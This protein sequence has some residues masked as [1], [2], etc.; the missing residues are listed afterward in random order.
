M[1]RQEGIIR[2]QEEP[3]GQSGQNQELGNREGKAG[4]ALQGFQAAVR[5]LDLILSV[6]ETQAIVPR[7]GCRVETEEIRKIM[8][9]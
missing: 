2:T 6:R 8:P 4:Q 9:M 3:D 1:K 7:T 5:S